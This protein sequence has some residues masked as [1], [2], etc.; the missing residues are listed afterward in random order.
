MCLATRPRFHEK[1]CT[2][3]PTDLSSILAF[4]YLASQQHLILDQFFQS[5][6]GVSGSPLFLFSFYLH[7]F[8]GD[9]FVSYSHLACYFLEFL[10]VVCVFVY[11][12]CIHV[13]MVLGCICTFVYVCIEAIKLT[14]MSFPLPL[15]WDPTDLVLT[16]KLHV[17]L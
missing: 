3:P 15:R 11:L 13:H 6:L 8:S 2:L 16:T 1:P 4:S 12:V 10:F 7:K 9:N 14:Q 5:L 17:G